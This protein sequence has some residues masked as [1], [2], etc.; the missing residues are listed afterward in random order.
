MTNTKYSK[1]FLMNKDTVIDYVKDNINYFKR[2]ASL[3]ADEIGDGNIN[4]VFVVRDKA[5][6]KSIV[7]KQA[8]TLLRSSGRPFDTHRNKIEAEILATEGELAPGSVPKIYDYNETMCALTMEDI[9]DYKNLRKELMKGKIFPKLADEI[10][11][12]MVD[13]ML[14]T[15]DLVMDR[16]EKKKKVQLFTNVDC[17]DITEDLVLTEPYYNYKNQN[18]ITEGEEDF[19]IKNL[20]QN[21]H[22]KAEVGKL[23]NNYMNNAQALIHGDLHTGSIFIND[24]GLKVIDP[25]FAFYGPIG[26]DTGNVIG[27]LFF[28]WANKLVTE[29]ENTEFLKWIEDAIR[30]V[31]DLLIYKFNKK[32]DECV[33]FPLYSKE[34]KKSYIDSIMSDTIGYAGTEIIRRTVG[35]SKVIEV[36]SVKDHEK[37]I[38]L[39]ELLVNV[40]IQF[41]LSR[42]NYRNGTD[43]VEVFKEAAKK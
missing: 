14:P 9:S 29:P 33:K 28:A 31:Y 1:H 35:D 40:G 21:E 19:V 10:T 8:D 27:N 12:F 23:R 16:H 38:K 5:S 42:S 37:R 26:Y 13:T 25:E 34:F 43:V 39:D 24:K 2:D 7:V 32:F 4:Y 22:L 18:I 3:E 20:Y 41:I 17:C 30:D 15:T 36:T 11:D 6:G